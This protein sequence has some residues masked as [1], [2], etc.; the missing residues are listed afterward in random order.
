M[1]GSTQQDHVVQIHQMLFEMAR[2]NFNHRIPLANCKAEMETMAVLINMVAE[3]MREAI[4][5]NGYVGTQSTHQF[6]T[7]ITFIL[8]ASFQIK[9]FTSEVISCMGY[10]EN[11]LIDA[12]F[13]SFITLDSFKQLQAFIEAST[14]LS[15]FSTVMSLEF[16]AKTQLHV[17]ACCS[18]GK[19]LNSE[20]YIISI[21]TPVKQESYH[22]IKYG[23]ETNK[24]QK[25]RKTD[26]LLI[27]KLYDYIVDNLEEPLPSVKILARK[28][29][30]NEYKL[31]DGFRHFFKTSIYKFYNDERLKRA[32]FMIEET[33]IPLK[34]IAVMN[35]F[36]DY[37]NFS[38]AFKKKYG[39]SPN[40]LP[41]KS[42]YL[43][44]PQINTGG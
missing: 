25:T 4:F 8:N 40:E 27:Q 13:S 2:G 44:L 23:N 11:E 3:E 43:E 24:Q 15:S 32:H 17:V 35:G 10:T 14:S 28:F 33:V 37:P 41:R 5:H 34:N 36:N 31:K 26:A 12:S 9:T 16:I 21:V 29:G 1:E 6:I 22:A 39:C 42:I 20:E 18:V 7:Q 38:K 30:T 19:L